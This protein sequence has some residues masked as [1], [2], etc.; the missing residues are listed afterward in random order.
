MKL[1]HRNHYICQACHQVW[2]TANADEGTTPFSIRCL[3]PECGG[4][5]MST[6]G[7]GADERDVPDA[8]FRRF[9]PGPN[10]YTPEL[11]AD[12]G[13]AVPPFSEDALRDLGEQ[14]DPQ[15]LI[16]TRP[17]WPKD[18]KSVWSNV[19]T[20]KPSRETI[21]MVVLG[22]HNM[23]PATLRQHYT[24]KV[25]YVAE[26]WR[27]FVARPGG[28]DYTRVGNTLVDAIAAGLHPH[29][30]PGS[31]V[32]RVGR[33]R[34]SMPMPPWASRLWFRLTEARRVALADIT[35]DMMQDSITS[36]AFPDP[37]PYL[38]ERLHIS[39]KHDDLLYIRGQMVEVEL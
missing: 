16:H 26:P 3:K 34:E 31:R 14:H 25:M 23:P 2:H 8:I 21:S 7:R 35:Q 32:I 39:R 30:R 22:E 5:C 38:A 17:R 15:V 27:L 4:T 11:L 10:L 33:Q 9:E 29:Q 36:F 20:L 1:T 37:R 6:R 19:L 24:G 18:A 12:Q 13:Y 28:M